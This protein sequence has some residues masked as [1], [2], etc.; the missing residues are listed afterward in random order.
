MIKIAI[1][2]GIAC[3]KSTVATML[4]EAGV[5]V[6]DADDVS[7][8][9]L[10]TGSPQFRQVVELFGAAILQPNGELDR[11]A[12]A[13]RVFSDITA[14]RR[15]EEIVHPVVFDGWTR[16]L[17]ARAEEG[18]SMVAVVIPLLFEGGFAAGWDALVCVTASEIVQMERLVTRGHT[19][20]EARQRM[21]SQM[22]VR[23]K[24]YRS[25]F[26]IINDSSKGVLRRQIDTLLKRIVEKAT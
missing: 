11:A 24:E 10:A 2:G 20:E 25:D 4:L 1:T 8:E 6:C 3:G 12:L 14:R 21:A 13:A 23:E 15:L 9:A 22:C 18:C 7:R 17:E 19:V 16:W 26:V 5:P